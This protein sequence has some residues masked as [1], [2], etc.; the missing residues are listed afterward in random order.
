MRSV[1]AG[2]VG[3]L[4]GGGKA[5]S[6]DV[7]VGTLLPL[8][9]GEEGREVGRAPHRQSRL[10][11]RLKLRKLHLL[12]TLDL[13]LLQ[14]LL[15]EEGLGGIVGVVGITRRLLLTKQLLEEGLLSLLLLLLQEGGEDGNV[16][17]VIVG[18]TAAVP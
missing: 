14:N 3:A 1:G 9:E 13:A 11:L 18:S 2:H 12:L 5:D 6:V 16:V 4:S 15:E 8:Q 7:I 10:R 17:V